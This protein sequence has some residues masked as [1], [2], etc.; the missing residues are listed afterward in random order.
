MP[1]G[2]AP[3]MTCIGDHPLSPVHWRHGRRTRAATKANRSCAN[4]SAKPPWTRGAP[5]QRTYFASSSARAVYAFVRRH[6]PQVWKRHSQCR[7]LERIDRQ[8]TRASLPLSR[9]L[10]CTLRRTPSRLVPA[11]LDRSLCFRP[12][13]VPRPSHPSPAA[14]RAGAVLAV[15]GGSD[16]SQQPQR[17]RLSL[18]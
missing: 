14:V 2:C 9:A 13:R 4:C 3:R 11:G 1:T 8:S 16:A 7:W 6:S 10:R 18:D 5:Q 15:A 17:V 12:E